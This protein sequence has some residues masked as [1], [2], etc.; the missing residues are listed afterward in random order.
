MTKLFRAIGLMSGTSMDG[1]DLALIES[2]G[3]EIINRQKFSYQFDFGKI[4]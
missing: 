1:I 3:K 4:I 2:N